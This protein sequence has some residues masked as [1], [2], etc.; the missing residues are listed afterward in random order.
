MMPAIIG[1][2]IK[3]D[4]LENVFKLSQNRDAISFNNII[5]KLEAI[6]GE[7]AMV[8]EEMRRRVVVG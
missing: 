3:I 7:S 2:E 8:A 1:I 5:Q 6:G 4:R